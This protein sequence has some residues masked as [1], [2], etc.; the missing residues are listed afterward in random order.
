MAVKSEGNDLRARYDD[1]KMEFPRKCSIDPIKPI[2]RRFN[3][4]VDLPA[5]LS[6]TGQKSV[7]QPFDG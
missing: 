3:K 6:G 7:Q 2:K 5:I 1:Y 4:A